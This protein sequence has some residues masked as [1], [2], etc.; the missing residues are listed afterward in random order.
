[1]EKITERRCSKCKETKP[2][3][4][5][6]RDKYQ[7]GGYSYLCKKCENKKSNKYYHKNQ[8]RRK[9]IKEHNKQYREQQKQWIKENRE[10]Y[11]ELQREARHRRK[12]KENKLVNDFTKND[13]EICLE[14]FSNK[15]GQVECCYCGEPTEDI[16][17]DHFIAVSNGGGYTATNIV[18]ACKS[19]NS[20]KQDKDFFEWYPSQ[21]FYSEERVDKIL[22]YFNS[23]RE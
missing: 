2:I 9:Y 16:E 6:Y 15:N 7:T 21:E 12:A 5:F 1:L 14:Y 4:E 11:N 23:L 22:K 19:C 17:K 3:T 10:R 8:K 13:W 18:P 20:S